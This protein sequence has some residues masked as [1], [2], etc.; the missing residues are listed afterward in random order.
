M[1]YYKKSNM[2]HIQTLIDNFLQQH[3]INLQVKMIDNNILYISNENSDQFY[4][5][6]IK[7]YINN[8]DIDVIRNVVRHD[9]SVVSHKQDNIN[10]SLSDLDKELK[11]YKIIDDNK[12]TIFCKFLTNIF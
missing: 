2:N 11:K 9:D 3:N 6:C 10:T 1:L 12:L 7:K 5:I 8:I 4:Q